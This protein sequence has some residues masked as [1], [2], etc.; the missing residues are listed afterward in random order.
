MKPTFKIYPRAKE[1]PSN[2][3]YV[4]YLRL[5]MNR[6]SK[7]YSLKINV[8]IPDID[9]YWDSR[10][11]Q[12]KKYPGMILND[13]NQA[14]QEIDKHHNKVRNIIHSFIVTDRL[15][16]FDEFERH[17]QATGDIKSS[18][19]DFATQ[20]VNFMKK[21]KAPSETLRSYNSYISKLK[22]YRSKLHFND[23][24]LDF[25]KEYHAYMIR[26]LDNNENTCHKSLS[27]IRTMLNR[28][29][30]QGIIKENIFK[31]YPLRRIPGR[32]DFLTLDELTI[33]GN[34]YKSGELKKYQMNV[35]SYFLFSCYTGLRY[36]DIKDLKF[37]DLKKENHSKVEK[38]FLRIKIHKTQDDISIPLSPY[39]IELLGEG[40]QNQ[41]VFK[42][43]T[44]QVTHRYL[45]EISKIAEIEKKIT[46]HSARHT[47]ATI[48]LSIGISLDGIRD[49]LG[50]K[51]LKTTMIYTKIMDDLRI[52]NMEKWDE[53]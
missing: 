52:R 9:K 14:N 5:T 34:L 10:I 44:N 29:I 47:F 25:V 40:F 22:K 24:T 15:I 53:L 50:H 42:V 31:R 1:N 49:L 13:I 8:Y 33:L 48:S 7:W 46:F 11:F 41:K 6:V 39:A 37:S 51:D 38:I 26:E 4:I 18:F 45:K 20:E 43:N 32:R 23:I 21:K 30:N 17:F 12:V 35:L 27:F 3:Q 16:S 2:G 19:Y 36:Q 28:A